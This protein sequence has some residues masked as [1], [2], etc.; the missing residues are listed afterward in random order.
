MKIVTLPD[1]VLR[2]KCKNVVVPVI[3]RD[4][5]EEIIAGMIRVM[6]ELDGVG[7]AAPQ[8]GIPLR[9]VVI[10]PEQTGIPTVMV[11]PIRNGL[12]AEWK[13]GEEGCLSVPDTTL[14]VRRRKAVS[15]EWR[16][17]DGKPHERRFDGWPARVV[18]HELQHLEGELIVDVG[19]PLK[20]RHR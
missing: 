5:Y 16:D 3:E 8:V 1:A 9:L 10:D 6:R 13:W 20:R 2:E 12:G 4:S 18:Q 7:L 19:R 14:R 17:L 11:N 15:V